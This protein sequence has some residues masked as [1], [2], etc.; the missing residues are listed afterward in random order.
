MADLDV[1]A[2]AGRLRRHATSIGISSISRFRPLLRQRAELRKIQK[3][4]DL[5]PAIDTR[6][7]RI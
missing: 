2:H 3:L 6:M 7:R 5:R 1:G 4:L